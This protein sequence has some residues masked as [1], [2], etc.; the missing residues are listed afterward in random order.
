MRALLDTNLLIS[1]LL[2]AERRASAIGAILTAAATGAFRLLFPPE[3]AEE[4]AETVSRRP[5]LTARIRPADI[6]ELIAAVE[7]LGETVPRLADEAPRVGRDPKDDYLIAQAVAAKA[8]YFVSWDKDLRDLG[9]VEGVRIV[10][11]SEFL[12]VLRESGRLPE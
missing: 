10:S 2:S 7:G 5:D 6:E 4:I 1:Y 3:V 11:P 12:R 9:E 8:D